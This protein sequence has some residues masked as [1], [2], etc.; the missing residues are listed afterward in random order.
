MSSLCDVMIIFRSW[1]KGLL[2]SF[3]S[4]F[5]KSVLHAH[6]L[7]TL[8]SVSPSSRQAEGFKEKGNAYYSKKDY[9]AAFNYYTKAI[10]EITVNHWD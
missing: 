6:L 1:L 7:L 9:S 4:L 8:I 10:G 3:G 2:N 5:L